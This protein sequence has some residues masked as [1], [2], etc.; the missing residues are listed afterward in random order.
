MLKMLAIGR[1]TK[2]LELLNITNE[3]NM[4]V[5]NFTLACRNNNETEY[6][7]CTAWNEVAKTIADNTAKGSQLYIE[8]FYKTTE[9]VDQ[10]TQIKH[11]RIFITV[12]KFEF[13]E[14]KPKKEGLLFAKKEN[15]DN[16]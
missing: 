4:K 11:R 1:L 12:E 9:Y 5:A 6:I 7:Q 8:G 14:S 10:A 16:D 13:L 3:K 15:L 2:E